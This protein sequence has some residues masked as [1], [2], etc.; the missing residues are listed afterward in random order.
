[1]APG[2]RDSDQPYQCAHTIIKSHAKAYHLY[3]STYKP[4]QQGIIGITLDSG[5]YEPKNPNSTNDVEAAERAIQFKVIEMPTLCI[6]LPAWV[7]KTFR[8]SSNVCKNDFL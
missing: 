8:S 1:M 3:N 7:V 2:I 5:W 4:T 6:I